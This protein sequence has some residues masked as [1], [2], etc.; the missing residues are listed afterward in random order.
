MYKKL[1]FR[2]LIKNQPRWFETCGVSECA[3]ATTV[4]VKGGIETRQTLVCRNHTD[5]SSG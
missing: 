5:P 1:L 4:A 3:V 2:F